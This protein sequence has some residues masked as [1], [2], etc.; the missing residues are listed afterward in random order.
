MDNVDKL[1]EQ[2]KEFDLNLHDFGDGITVM[3]VPDFNGQG[4]TY[5][6]SSVIYV[7]KKVTDHTWLIMPVQIR[8]P[9]REVMEG[10]KGQLFELKEGLASKIAKRFKVAASLMEDDGPWPNTFQM[11]DSIETDG[12]VANPI[13][14][15]ELIVRKSIANLA[16]VGL[17]ISGFSCHP[18]TWMDVV[19]KEFM[20][21]IDVMGQLGPVMIPS[22]TNPIL[23]LNTYCGIPITESREEPEL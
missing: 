1:N 6:T 13:S 14:E 2:L 17:R 18:K 22:R 10:P 19:D 5:L 15:R 16:R 23:L 20:S 11:L 3:P 7:Q 8:R 4:G 21:G 12:K 9:L